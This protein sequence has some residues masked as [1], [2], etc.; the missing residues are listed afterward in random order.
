[1]I[2]DDEHLGQDIENQRRFAPTVFTIVRNACSRSS[3]S[4]ILYLTCW[5]RAQDRARTVALFSTA[6]TLAGFFNSPISG[7]LLQLDGV[8]GW[9]GWQWLF[10]IEGIP[11]VIVGL[12]VLAVLPDKPQKARW[13]SDAERE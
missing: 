12:V 6:G 4:A 7:K 9:A 13:L 2:D 3:E 5:F 1:M 10:L 11:A 8:L